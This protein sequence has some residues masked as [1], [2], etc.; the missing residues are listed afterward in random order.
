MNRNNSSTDDIERA[1]CDEELEESNERPVGPLLYLKDGR[2]VRVRAMGE[3]GEFL[4]YQGS[5]EQGFYVFEDTG[6]QATVVFELD[7]PVEA[8]TNQEED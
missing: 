8:D 2:A 7:Q 1:F 3:D 5:P 6:E 4:T